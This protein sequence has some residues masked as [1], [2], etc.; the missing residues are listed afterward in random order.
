[1]TLLLRDGN[2][3]FTF[4]FDGNT[5]ASNAASLT[6]AGD[7]VEFQI[8]EYSRVKCQNFTNKTVASRMQEAV[9]DAVVRAS[10]PPGSLDA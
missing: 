4:F 10:N 3:I 8:S 5:P 1:M 7:E 2:Q 9:A 6:Q